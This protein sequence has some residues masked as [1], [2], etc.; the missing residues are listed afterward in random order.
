M[1][2]WEVVDDF[3]DSIRIAWNESA[4]FNFQEPVGGEWVDYDSFICYG[5]DNE[6]DALEFALEVLA[7]EEE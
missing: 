4:T 3:G 5:I 6:N 7:E 2:Y 1:K